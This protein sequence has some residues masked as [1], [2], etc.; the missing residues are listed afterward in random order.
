[1]KKWHKGIFWAW[2]LSGIPG[3][4]FIIAF[5]PHGLVNLLST[6]ICIAGGIASILALWRKI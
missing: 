3:G 1:M 6:G 2:A 5:L 4:I